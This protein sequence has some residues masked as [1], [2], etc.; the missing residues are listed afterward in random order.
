MPKE[1]VCKVIIT[2]LDIP[3]VTLTYQPVNCD[4]TNIEKSLWDIKYGAGDSW[5]KIKTEKG[6][7]SSFFKVDIIKI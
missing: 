5:K 6:R 2:H 3:E 1:K 4:S 7:N